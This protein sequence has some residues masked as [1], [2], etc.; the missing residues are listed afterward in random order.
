MLAKWE[1][2]IMGDARAY[3]PGGQAAPALDTPRTEKRLTLTPQLSC[4]CWA[5][6]TPILCISGKASAAL[7][8][9]WRFL[10][11]A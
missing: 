7:C 3:Y 11:K 1:S 4:A 9:S 8:Y 5:R 6:H 10:L 2:E